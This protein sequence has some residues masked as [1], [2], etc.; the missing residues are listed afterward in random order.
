MTLQLLR[1]VHTYH[2]ACGTA[3]SHPV[4]ALSPGSDRGLCVD[5]EREAIL[6]SDVLTDPNADVRTWAPTQH[7]IDRLLDAPARTYTPDLEI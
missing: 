7:S 4:G 6:S 1:R 3:V 5:C 2:C